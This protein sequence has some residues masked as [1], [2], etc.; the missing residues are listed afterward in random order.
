MIIVS[1]GF[2]K[3]FLASAASELARRGLLA[4]LVT[5]AYPTPGIGRPFASA[6][7]QEQRRLARLLARSEPIPAQLVLPIGCQKDC[8]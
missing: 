3:F 1:N 6:G 4:A 5:G 2:N 8:T 7:S